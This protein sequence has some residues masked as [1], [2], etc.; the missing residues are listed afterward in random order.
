MLGLLN[1]TISTIEIL[2][3]RLVKLYEGTTPHLYT[4]AEVMDIYN[5]TDNHCWPSPRPPLLR[6]IQPPDADTE[7]Y[8]VRWTDVKGIIE[9]RHLKFTP[10]NYGKKWVLF[11]QCPSMD[12]IEAIK[13][14]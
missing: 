2:Y 4:W 7:Y 1:D 14:E 9:Y 13:W 3:E 11:S 10:N 6:L 8:W 12:Q 5:M